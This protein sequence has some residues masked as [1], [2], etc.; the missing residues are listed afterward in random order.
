MALDAYLEIKDI[1]GEVIV[2]GAIDQ[3][4]VLA[5][6][7]GGSSNANVQKGMTGLA[8][9]NVNLQDFSITKYMDIS[10]PLLFQAMTLG[11]HIDTMTFTVRKATGK[12]GEEA[13]LKY[14][15]KEIMV[16]SMTTGG[17]TGEDR[18]TENLTFAFAN[19]SLS[20]RQQ[21][22]DGTLG[23]ETPIKWDIGTGTAI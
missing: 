9:G 5:F 10:T 11:N 3:I 13:F 1:K 18:L 4:F 14:V 17:S 16:T 8:P 19:I 2:P 15:F 22:V 6:S 20:Y 7:F 21:M 12:G 23:T